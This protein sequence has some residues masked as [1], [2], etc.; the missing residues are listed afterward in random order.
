MK[1]YD[2]NK[3]RDNVKWWA[4]HKHKSSGDIQGKRTE[5]QSMDLSDQH[6]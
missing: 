3:C 4:E 2:K 6:S 1:K 5:E